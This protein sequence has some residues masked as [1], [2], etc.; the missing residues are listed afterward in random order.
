[1]ED[2]VSPLYDENTL[3]IFTDLG[4]SVEQITGKD[5]A[6][7]TSPD[8]NNV[9]LDEIALGILRGILSIKREETLLEARCGR[10]FAWAWVRIRRNIC[11]VDTLD[12]KELVLSCLPQKGT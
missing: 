12:R 7:D 3:R 8:D 2:K 4:V 10:G 11:V 6:A 5:T 9:I 1:M